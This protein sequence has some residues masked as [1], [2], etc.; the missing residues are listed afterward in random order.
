M[1][2]HQ[3]LE[4]V[5]E[6]PAHGLDHALGFPRGAGG[7]H[8]HRGIVELPLIINERGGGI[9]YHKV[10]IAHGIGDL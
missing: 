2:E 1:V 4:L 5:D 10:L 6:E 8:D 9:L 3:F 7:E